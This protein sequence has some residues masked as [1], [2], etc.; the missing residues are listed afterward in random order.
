MTKKNEYTD[1]SPYLLVI[2]QSKTIN[3]A[4]KWKKQ[5]ILEDSP[6]KR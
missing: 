1:F 3:R 5:T 6:T 4:Y 2:L